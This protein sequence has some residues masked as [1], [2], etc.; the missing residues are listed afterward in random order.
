[1]DDNH[2]LGGG[3]G[4]RDRCRRLGAGRRKAGDEREDEKSRCAQAEQTQWDQQEQGP[5]WPACRLGP[6]GA[7]IW[8]KGLAG[9]LCVGGLW[10]G[11]QGVGGLGRYH[12]G[13]GDHPGAHQLEIGV[14]YLERLIRRPLLGD[15]L[16]QPGTAQER[17]VTA[18]QV[19][20]P[21]ASTH[22]LDA[23]VVA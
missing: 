17:A 15:P 19:G 10:N 4:S 21:V 5:A 11:S 18:A 16:G 6:A 14:A 22:L 7:G 13:A 1:M 23:H 9:R 2:H 8:R 20:H 3:R 12:L